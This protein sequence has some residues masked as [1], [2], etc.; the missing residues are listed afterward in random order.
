MRNRRVR[1]IAP[2]PKCLHAR[3]SVSLPAACHRRSCNFR[4][5]ETFPLDVIGTSASHGRQREY[6]IGEATHIALAYRASLNY[7]VQGLARFT[8]PNFANP[9]GAAIIAAATGP[10]GPLATGPASVDI[11]L[12]DPA[13]LSAR[14]A[15][16]DRFELLADTAWTGWSSLQ[17]LWVVRDSGAIVSVTP[18]EAN[19]RPRPTSAV[20]K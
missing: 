16:G 18:E 17:E 8:S 10:N 9:I 4:T 12:P 11:E 20:C 6:H 14:Q 15:L 7:Q 1:I 3:I 19:S 13:L 2:A 5:R